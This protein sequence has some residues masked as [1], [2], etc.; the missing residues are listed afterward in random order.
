PTP[1]FWLHSAMMRAGP[2]PPSFLGTAK[3]VTGL[4]V[5]PVLPRLADVA[6]AAT[7]TSAPRSSPSSPGRASAVSSCLAVISKVYADASAQAVC[8]RTAPA[9]S[10]RVLVEG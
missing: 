1:P 8:T 9:G 6:A 2:C 3:L 7:S 5:G 10:P 4:P